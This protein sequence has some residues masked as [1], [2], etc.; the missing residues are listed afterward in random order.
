MSANLFLSF[1]I[2][3]EDLDLGNNDDGGIQKLLQS[4]LSPRHSPI[5]FH[6]QLRQSIKSSMLKEVSKSV[7]P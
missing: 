6:H 1:L 7:D 2:D 3:E 5:P 4:S